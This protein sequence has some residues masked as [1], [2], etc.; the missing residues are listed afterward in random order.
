MGAICAQE[1]AWRQGRALF[2]FTD[3]RGKQGKA[4][5]TYHAWQ[6]PNTY[7][8]PHT[9]LGRGRGRHHNRQLADLRQQGG[10]GNGQKGGGSAAAAGVLAGEE[11][12]RGGGVVD[13]GGC[14]VRGG[15]EVWSLEGRKMIHEGEGWLSRSNTTC[16][17]GVLVFLLWGGSVG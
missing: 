16:R 14:G 10:A 2:P 3:F 12:P 7:F 4:G 6:L 13:D 17:P 5:Q 11:G 15:T 8:G 1:Q 9:H